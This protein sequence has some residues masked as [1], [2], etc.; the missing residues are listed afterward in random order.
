MKYSFDMVGLAQQLKPATRSPDGLPVEISNSI[1]EMKLLSPKEIWQARS[2]NQTW[3][4]RIEGNSQLWKHL[5]IHDWKSEYAIQALTYLC[6]LDACKARS[7]DFTTR[8]W[9]FGVMR[10]DLG[11]FFWRILAPRNTGLNELHL[12]GQLLQGPDV[13]VFPELRRLD[14]VDAKDLSPKH[15]LQFF[16]MLE[17]LTIRG[18]WAWY[19]Y[20][21]DWKWPG[22]GTC[23]SLKRLTLKPGPGFVKADRFNMR[24]L[25]LAA[26]NLESLEIHGYS[27]DRNDAGLHHLTGLKECRLV[28]CDTQTTRYVPQLPKSLQTLVFK[29]GRAPP[30][31]NDRVLPELPEQ[32]FLPKLRRLKTNFPGLQRMSNRKSV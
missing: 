8:H 20:Q 2:V 30:H 1:M 23:D 11:Q 32:P 10:P 7:I 29:L 12:N 3:K 17:S 22:Q 16:P 15:F 27:L 21:Q 25:S 14:V 13:V 5:T 9:D 6:R 18:I 19:H 28:D 26:P 31:A 4:R 24:E